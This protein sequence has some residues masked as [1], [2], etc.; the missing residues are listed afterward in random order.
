MADKHKVWISK[1]DR[2]LNREMEKAL[3]WLDWPSIIASG[4]R[5]AIKPNLTYPIPKD[6]VTTTPI[7]L[8]ALIQILT[9]RSGNLAVVESDGGSNAFTADEAFAGH[10]IDRI[11]RRYGIRAVNL[12]RERT[13]K[14][15]ATIG[16][17]RVE[18]ELPLILTDETDVFITMPVPKVHMMTGV[19]LGFKNQWGCLPDPKRLREHHEFARKVLAIN[20]ILKPQLTIFDG[21]YFLDRGGPLAGNPIG[22]NLVIASRNTGAGSLLCCEVMG[23]DPR[24]I[25]HLRLAIAEKMMPASLSEIQS[26]TEIAQFKGAPFTLHRGW[27]QW[28]TLGVFRSRLA[29][30]MLY[31]SRL[32]RPAH[33]LLYFFR[34]QPAEY[35]PKW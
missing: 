10:G 8:E 35:L 26:N 13:R 23:V 1:T 6:G 17:R 9:S 3:G 21:T 16:G 29:T 22:K 34:G 7:A 12:S 5:V 24:R 31:D 33:R 20:T 27:S 14:M 11:A 28:L 18:V 32:A 4:A 19:S 30:I 2:D 15:S 25:T